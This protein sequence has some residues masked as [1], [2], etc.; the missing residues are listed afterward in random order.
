[1][2]KHIKIISLS[3]FII[4]L[5]CVFSIA[6]VDFIYKILNNPYPGY[7]NFDMIYQPGFCTID[8]YSNLIQKDGITTN[9]PYFRVLRNG[10]IAQIV[11]NSLL[12]YN[13][14][15]E[16]IDEITNPTDKTLDFHDYIQ[17]RNGN[18][19]LLLTEYVTVDM[20]EIVEGGD[21]A[22]IVLNNLLV[23][24]NNKGD[25]LWLWNALDHYKFSDATSDVIL[26]QKS[27]DF[28]HI[29]SLDEDIN[30]N[31]LVSVRHLDELSLIDKSTG[32]FIWRLGGYKSKG[33]QFTFTND[34]TS[35]FFGF[36]HQHTAEFL[37]NGNILVFDNGNL[38]TPQ[39]SRVVE[40]ELNVKDKKATKVWEYRA[41]PDIYTQAMGSSFRLPNG[42]TLISFP[43]GKILEVRKDK[44]IALELDVVST[45][46]IYRV[47]KNY[48][49]LAYKTRRLNGN[50]EYDFNDNNNI[51]G[52]KI[53]ISN[54]TINNVD[55]YLQKHNYSPVITKFKDSIFTEILP[56][57]WVFSPDVSTFSIAGT[58]KLN[59]STISGFNDPKKLII[60]KRDNENGG[61]FELL[62]TNF[63]STSNEI[64][65]NFVGFGEFIVAYI[66]LEAPKLYYPAN[67]AYTATNGMLKWK[68]VIGANKYN[69]QI[70]KNSTF[71]ND[72]VFSGI[73]S[74]LEYYYKNLENS[75]KYYWRVNSSN[76]K[77][78]SEWSEVFS[79]VTEIKNPELI[80]PKNDS[81]G[82]KLQDTLRWTKVEEADHYQIQIS[83]NYNFILPINLDRVVYNNECPISKLN[84]N[85]KYYWRVRAYKNTD[86]SSWSDIYTFKTTIATPVLYFPKNNEINIIISTK[87]NWS[88]VDGAEKYLIQISETN[89]FIE[90]Y[91]KEYTFNSNEF[92][93]DNLDFNKN[94]FWRVKAL[95]QLD[96]SSWSEIFYFSTVLQA[97][98][99][100][101]PKLNDTKVAVNPELSWEK[102][103]KYSYNLQVSES[104]S[105]LENTIDTNNISISTFK[106]NELKPNTGYYWRVKSYENSKYSQWSNV[107]YFITN[108]AGN[109]L[110]KPKLLYPYKESDIEQPIE[111]V[112]NRKEGAMRFKIQIAKD[113][114]FNDIYIEK[115]NLSESRY[116]VEEFE[117]N[118]IYYW[119]VKSYS[120]Y[121]SSAWSDIWNFRVMNYIQ[122]IT[123]IQPK[124]NELQVPTIGILEWKNI[125]DVHYFNVQ[126]ANDY[127]FLDLIE[128]KDVYGNNV[129]HY[130]GLNYNK[131]YYWRVRY[132]KDDIISEWSEIWTFYSAS[133]IVLS[134]PE[135]TSPTANSY[136]VPINGYI[137]WKKVENANSYKISIST[138]NNR[139]TIIYNVNNTN[140][141]KLKYSELDYGTEY[142]IKISA[143]NDNSTSV[144]SNSIMFLTELE[145]PKIISPDNKAVDLEKNGQIIWTLKND[146]YLYQLQIDTLKE[147][148]SAIID[149]SLDELFYN[150]EL[151]LEQTYFV[152][153]KS[154]NDTNESQWSDVVRFSTKSKGTSISKIDNFTIKYY[155][156]PVKN[157]INIL[158]DNK[159]NYEYFN[160]EIK[161]YNIFGEL[162]YCNKIFNENMTI[163]ISILPNGIYYLN[164]GTKYYKIIKEL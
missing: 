110:L 91:F 52:V 134:T 160:K 80:F 100:I 127:E 49:D 156:N 92:I 7:L 119:R 162:K 20:S 12:I 10:N 31:I 38:R 34:E 6:Q 123:L 131:Q 114:N 42:N 122:Q 141:T 41:S 159:C 94:Y 84:N 71:S 136:K 58:F 69:I 64:S 102:I 17:L 24:T 67:N 93:V 152:R 8:N 124:N 59:L 66:D 56:Y 36:S 81:Y 40:Y 72:I 18:Y 116:K 76:V 87:L 90:N 95:R 63:N 5:N 60:Y 128:D 107:N 11:G 16:L 48:C 78:T 53:N 89:D 144:W 150:F 2:K 139:N 61:E 121:D 23:E 50:N 143:F 129:F 74:T 147:F 103:G 1:M 21:T 15:M 125:S 98:K 163:D 14:N 113:I 55:V 37:E 106:I 62:N 146:I 108:L 73:F 13:K 26:T 155:P 86:S 132:S 99:L 29:N 88:Y 68:N 22:A 151:E 111:F 142:F 30:G 109:F 105:F 54:S 45:F 117:D 85:I 28:T 164:I 158:I 118:T 135:L 133:T 4:I 83:T 82:I 153:V 104:D 112:W 57:R 120:K 44:T 97:P 27:F 126:I 137:T 130:S 51:T 43:N 101:F 77:D 138:K 32:D 115:N 33:N 75:T 79:F 148:N 96:S 157:I 25:I 47:F 9:S 46:P 149:L 65:A 39:F 35:G 154:Y 140:E 19:L 70:S 3:I 161:I 145:P